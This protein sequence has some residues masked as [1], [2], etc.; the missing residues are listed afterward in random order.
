[1]A[2]T[3]AS[4]QDIR[5]RGVDASAADD[6][7]VNRALLRAGIVIEAYC[8]RDFRKREETYRVDGGGRRSLFLDDRPVIE[9]LDL[10]VDGYAVNAGDFVVYGDAGYI[11]LSGGT[12]I[13]TG[14]AGVF[15]SGSQNVEVHGWF[16]YEAPPPEVREACILLTLMFLRMMGAEVNVSQSQANTADRAV[17]IKRV[18]VDDLSVEYEYPRDV[19]AASA[20]KKS[21]GLVEADRLLWRFRKDLEAIAI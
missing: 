21:T 1:V 2:D 10:K 12:S 11:R 5:D 9:V 7:T 6:T 15:A 14:Y 13:F 4:V 19:A 3:Y 17:G 8:G 20:Q 18:K 16:G